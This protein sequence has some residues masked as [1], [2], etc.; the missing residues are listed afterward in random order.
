MKK[1]FLALALVATVFVSCNKTNEAKT[2]GPEID[3]TQV[4]IDSV[5]VDSVAVDTTAVK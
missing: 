1:A 5:Q 2:F 4:E 3:S